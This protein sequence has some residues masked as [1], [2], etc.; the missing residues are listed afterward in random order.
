MPVGDKK[1]H[2]LLINQLRVGNYTGYD[3]ISQSEFFLYLV[4]I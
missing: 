4:Y 1:G 2:H 3:M